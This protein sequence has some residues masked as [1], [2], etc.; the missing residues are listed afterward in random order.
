MSQIKKFLYDNGL[1]ICLLAL[2]VV[3]LIGQ[4]FTGFFSYNDSLKAAK[5]A[6]VGVLSFLASGTFLDGMMSNWQAAILQLTVLVSFSSVLR[7]KGAAHSRK[8]V[9][10]ELPNEAHS[11]KFRQKPGSAERFNRLYNNSLSVTLLGLFVLLFLLHSFFGWKFYNENQDLQHAAHTA[12]LAYLGS[13]SFWFSAFQTWEAEFFAIAFYIIASIFLRQENSP[14][15]KK[16]GASDSD[17][18]DTND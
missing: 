5:L 10:E 1:S 12:Y 17:T 15:S 9:N 8:P 18:G 11:D 13:S 3:C 6:T 2:F 4:A 7:Q 16:E 14:E